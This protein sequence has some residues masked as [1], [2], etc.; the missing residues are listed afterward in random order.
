[1][2]FIL[3]FL[4]AGFFAVNN[5]LIKKGMRAASDN[6]N[7]VLVTIVTNVILLG[8]ILIG[9]R[10][11]AANPAPFS[12]K[13][14]IFFVLAG[15][16]TTFIGRTTLFA[17]IRKIGPSRA[18]AIKNSQ[19]IFTLFFAIFLL[20][21]AFGVWPWVGMSLIFGGLLVQGV[22]FFHA[23]GDDTLNRL[24]LLFSVLSA[25]FFGVG[26]VVRKQAMSSFAD[27]F[28][29]AFIG[30]LIALCSFVIVSGYR[31]KLL[32]IIKTNLVPLN[33]YYVW[34]GVMSSL[35]VLSFFT[36]IWFIKV[37]YTGAIVAMEPVLTVILSRLLL[38][39]TEDQISIKVVAV[40]LLIFTGAGIIALTG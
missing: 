26:Q 14:V 8:L 32:S 29:G 37:A 31:R 23:R 21:E 38:S 3:A 5:I 13:G 4:S 36:S 34:A 12:W 20:N 35:A 16:L 27:P 2:G 28:A 18:V 17:G 30:A 40:A 11:A 6:N 39:S 15:M 7:G 19:P 22:Q 9:Y 33:R 10:I 1:M 25:L 24:G